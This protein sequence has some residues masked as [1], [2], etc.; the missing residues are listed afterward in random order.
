MCRIHSTDVPT[1]KAMREVFIHSFEN[2]DNDE[3]D[4]ATPHRYDVV[5]GREKIVHHHIGNKRYLKI[6][7]MNRE[8]YQTAATRDIKTRITLCILEMVRSCG[9]RFLKLNKKEQEYQ[10]VGDEYARE[11]IS[12]AL[13]SA[14]DPT[15]KRIRKKRT[16]VKITYTAEQD[17]RFNAMLQ[18]QKA[19]F[20]KLIGLT[21]P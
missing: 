19:I 10:D 17:R 12:H 13:R 1:V 4:G 6:I 14:K 11:K 9:G 18:D 7:Q 20:K 8:K 15:Q 3:I 21:K 16:P 5:C 2:E